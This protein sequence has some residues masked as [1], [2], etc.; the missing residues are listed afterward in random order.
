MRRFYNRPPD[1]V[2]HDLVGAV[3][4]LRDRD[5]VVHARVVE[6]EAY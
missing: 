6:S 2:A 4:V 1:E 3:L 5:R